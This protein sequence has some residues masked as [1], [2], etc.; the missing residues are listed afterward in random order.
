MSTS[1]RLP[2]NLPQNVKFIIST[3]PDIHGILKAAESL[4]LPAENFVEVKTL[5]EDSAWNIID[6]WLEMTGRKVSR[7]TSNISSTNT[8]R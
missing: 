7:I 5:D 2:E 4:D 6:K 8:S 3:L 1:C